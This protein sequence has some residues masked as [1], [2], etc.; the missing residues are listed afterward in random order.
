ME[1]DRKM[2]GYLLE[3]KRSLPRAQQNEFNLSSPNIK[4]IVL[5]VHRTTTNNE[6]KILAAAFLAQAGRSRE[7]AR[8]LRKNLVSEPIH[9]SEETLDPQRQTNP[10]SVN[11]AR[12]NSIVNTTLQ[13]QVSNSAAKG[14]SEQNKRLI[15]GILPEFLENID[16]SELPPL[17]GSS[18]SHL[19]HPVKAADTIKVSS[20]AA[21]SL[22]HRTALLDKVAVFLTTPI[23][24]SMPIKFADVAIFLTTPIELSMPIKFAKKGT[25]ASR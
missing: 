14:A 12:R 21:I 23:D 20:A 16:I 15:A 13:K 3:I 4:K 24:L 18:S 2:A 9:Q 25:D 19:G 10:Q 22:R 5:D 7:N 8:Q 11:L 6:I 17:V 1:I